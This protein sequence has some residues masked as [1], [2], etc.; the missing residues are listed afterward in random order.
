MLKTYLEGNTADAD[1]AAVTVTA[2]INGPIEAI[3]SPIERDDT[4]SI[5]SS[6]DSLWGTV[7]A[8][9]VQVPYD[10]PWQNKLVALV[11]ATTS[12]P[13]PAHLDVDVRSCRGYGH[14]WSDLG[15]I[16]RSV[17][18]DFTDKGFLYDRSNSSESE[19]AFPRDQWFSRD[20]WVNFN[21]FVA[22]VSATGIKNLSYTGIKL[23]QGVLE[24]RQYYAS[25][26]SSMLN[27]NL[28][29][30]AVWLLYAGELM[31]E[32]PASNEVDRPSRDRIW[33]LW[34]EKL[35]DL[36]RDEGLHRNTRDWAEGAFQ[37]MG[38]IESL[39]KDWVVIE[40]PTIDTSL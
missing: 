28:T 20:E 34:K 15:I 36:M 31:Y 27:D 38:Y 22:R 14:I 39:G 3:R 10:H 11:V 2:T 4:A 13:A 12:L 29:A 32:R 35:S 1:S 26:T 6:V 5:A 9:A 21:A 17:Y 30:A 40:A 16:G 8:I 18:E 33:A 19:E 23:L 24:G 7:L 37:A 25:I